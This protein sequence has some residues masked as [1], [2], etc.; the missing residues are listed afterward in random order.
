[1][2]ESETEYCPVCNDQIASRDGYQ[3][4]PHIRWCET[5]GMW[6]PPDGKRKANLSE[7]P[8]VCGEC[9]KL[10]YEDED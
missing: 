1:M 9:G 6:T 5:C 8:K 2:L 4:C 10:F 7:Y 3:L